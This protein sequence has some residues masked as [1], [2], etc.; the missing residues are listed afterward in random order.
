MVDIRNSVYHKVLRVGMLVT[1]LVLVFQSGIISNSTRILSSNTTQYLANSVGAHV[2]VEPTELNTLTA[3]I[4]AQKLALEQRESAIRERE[5]EIGLEPGEAK[6]AR[7]TYILAALLSV[8]LA[9]IIL[10]Y[11]LDYLRTRESVK[12][13]IFS[14]V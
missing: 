4:T 3:E 14:T 13:Q 11:I 5:I 8:L 7:E 6:L 2:A 10:N 1:A 9:L 12:Q